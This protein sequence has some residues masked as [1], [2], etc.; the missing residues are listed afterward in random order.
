SIFGAMPP[1]Y[2]LCAALQNRLEFNH[3]IRGSSVFCALLAFA[4][5]MLVSPFFPLAVFKTLLSSGFSITD[6]FHPTIFAF[7]LFIFLIGIAIAVVALAIWFWLSLGFAL[8]TG[9]LLSGVFVWFFQL[10]CTCTRGGS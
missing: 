3:A 4:L 2:F 8:L 9:F 7:D 1:L 5:L 10:V 6:L